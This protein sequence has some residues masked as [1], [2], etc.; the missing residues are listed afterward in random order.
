MSKTT[1][2]QPISLII[3]AVLVAIE[4]LVVAVYGC[5]Y[6][7]AI[8]EGESKL[9]AAMISLVVLIFAVAAFLIAATRG[10][11]KHVRWSRSAIVFWQTCQLAIAYGSFT[12][13]GAAAGFWI[14]SA[15]ILFSIAAIGLAFSKPVLDRTRGDV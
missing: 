6:V 3:L 4:A 8:F 12:G 14:G 13:P 15:L 5:T 11:L 2:S 7:L 9:L 10:L 1:R